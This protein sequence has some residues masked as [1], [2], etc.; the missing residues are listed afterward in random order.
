MRLPMRDA[1]ARPLII[2]RGLRMA[3]CALIGW[4]SAS[5]VP[6]VAA[7]PVGL[8]TILDGNAFIYRGSG[9]GQPVEGMQVQSGD[10]LDVGEGG[11]LRIEMPDKTDL[12][13]GPR[14]DV[15]V[16]SSVGKGKPDRWIYVLRG[17]VK[18][19]SDRRDKGV[20]GM[21]VRSPL[22]DVPPNQAIVVLHIVPE[23]AQV[24]SQVGEARVFDA[25]VPASP[26]TLLRQGD[27]FR[28]KA[29]GWKGATDPSAMQ[30]F[31][32]GI[33]RAFRDS[34]PPL[35]G[36]FNPKEEKQPGPAPDFVY[37][38]VEPWLKAELPFRRQ[39]VQRW[40]AKADNAAFRAALV[41]NLAA[42]PEWDPILF[43]EKYRPKPD[44]EQL[45]KL[46]RRP[47]T[48]DAPPPRPSP[49]TGTTGPGG[50]PPAG[51]RQP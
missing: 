8:V 36:R 38:D 48:P 35:A 26:G 1:A 43:P 51:G 5:A 28:R 46:L 6:A 9:R 18:L 13:L 12:Q 25:H 15:M 29:G 22:V 17:W 30:A 7:D 44:A 20:P 50:V 42:H 3:A 41:S 4:A 21:E 2:D 19:A 45:D 39:F 31:V 23:E 14:S 27:L 10:I 24:F 33:P 47:G 32:G 37:A 40:R 34:L 11:F 16:T 49:V